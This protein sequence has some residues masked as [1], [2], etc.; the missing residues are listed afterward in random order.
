ME[1]DGPRVLVVDDEPHLR[2]V[3]EVILQ[4]EGYR[5]VSAPDG[6]T[7]LRLAAEIRPDLA[8]LDLV[9]PG[10]SGQEVCQKLKERYPETRIVYFTGKI[11][12]F[13]QPGRSKFLR[14][15]DGIITKPASRKQI[16]HRIRRALDK[17]G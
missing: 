5:V 16:L 2:R 7:A 10:M 4:K 3:L 6:V 9:L 15:A 13:D 14:E 8:V 12:P 1:T 17:N 11:D